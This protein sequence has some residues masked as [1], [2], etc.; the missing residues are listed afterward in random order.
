[1]EPALSEPRLP[2]PAQSRT[3]AEDRRMS[4][5][6]FA[7]ALIVACFAGPALAGVELPAGGTVEKVDFE[8]HVMGLFGKAGCNNGSCHGSF[9]GKNGFRL[10]LFGFD[11]DKDYAALTREV[12]GRRID[13]INPDNSLL[14][15]KATGS[16]PHEGGAR[17]GKDSWQYQVF[18]EW[19]RQGAPRSK[20]TGEI[21]DIAI[22]PREYVFVTSGKPARLRVTARFVDGSSEDIT[23]FCDF[24]VQDDGVA[25]V[26][27]VG[28]VAAVRPGDSGLAVLYRGKVAAVRLLVP[29]E[30]TGNVDYPKPTGYLDRE[31]FAKLKLLNVSPSEAASDLE[32]LRRVTI[33]AT[34]ALPTPDEVRTFLADESSDKRAKKIEELLTSPR[35]AALWATKFSDVTGNNTQAL[36]QPADMQMKRSQMWHDWIRTRIEKNVP[37]DQIVR[38]ILLA[39]S[40]EGKSPDE[41]L[42]QTKKVDADSAKFDTTEYAKRDTLDLFWRRQAAVPTIELGEKVAAA[43]LG[44]RLECAQCH[45]HPY[46]R[47]TQADYR[48]FANLF[49][50]VT[51]G[52]N[53][54]STPEMKKLVETENAERTKNSMGKNANQINTVREMFV[55]TEVAKGKRLPLLTHP[56][57]NQ[58][59]NPKAPAGPEFKFTPGQDIRADLFAWMRSPDNPFFARSFVNRVWGQYFGIG[60]VDP[61]DDFS[62]A[63]PPTNARLLDALAR[64]FIDHNYDI[65]HIE[66]TILNSRTYQTSSVPNQTNRFDRVNFARSYVRPM[67]AEVVVD[68]VNDAL[69]TSE[70]YNFVP[71]VKGEKGDPVKSLDGRRMTVIGSSRMNNPNLA[72]ALRIFGRPPRTTACDCERA[73]EPALPQTLFRMTDPDLLRKMRDP[74]NR[75]AILLKDKGRPDDAVLDEMFLATL[76][77]HPRPDE[78][79]TFK[80]HRAT[81]SDR[82][83][84]FTDVVWALLNTREFILNH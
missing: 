30:A 32:F 37:Y 35:H 8:R 58:P 50:G 28:E 48:A 33:D 53:Q 20:G 23:P 3:F 38:G 13:L 44:V 66:R 51:F 16:I 55:T 29:A 24:R 17:F 67:L 43:F 83:G 10:S 22:S 75:V 68:V 46:D 70:T 59:L 73:M 47:W 71:V 27:P 52:K 77:R 49:V 12:Q 80:E 60:L 54:F 34:G 57:T 36:E 79:A 63:N 81:T 11:P 42:E 7:C 61:V 5:P 78:I 56:D 74:K 15:R 21:V 25:R 64:D 72:Y 65:R 26:S 9:Q 40:R 45:K 14:L 18:R 2:L 82:A 76:T 6:R 1:M 31:V 19:I 62:Q 69:G 84:A 41:W 39:T 4:V